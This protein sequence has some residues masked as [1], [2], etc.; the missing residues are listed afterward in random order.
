MIVIPVVVTG[1]LAPRRRIMIGWLRSRKALREA[2][3]AYEVAMLNGMIADNQRRL[4]ELRAWRE[5][6]CEACQVKV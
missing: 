2:R 3:A 6:P 5:R 4:D 1:P